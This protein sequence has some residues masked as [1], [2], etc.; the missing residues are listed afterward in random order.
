M[1]VKM[2]NL[3]PSLRICH[4]F[5]GF[6]RAYGMQNDRLDAGGGLVLEK[7]KC[8]RVADGYKYLQIAITY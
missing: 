1:N 3:F 8:V 6:H 2:K 4:T 5:F 7:I